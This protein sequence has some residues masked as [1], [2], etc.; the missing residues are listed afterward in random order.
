M[1]VTLFFFLYLVFIHPGV[2]LGEVPQLMADGASA[3]KAEVFDPKSVTEPWKSSPE[4]ISYGRSIYEA[5]CL[6]CHGDQG[7]GDGAAGAGLNPKPRNLVEGR[8]TQG[9]DSI[10]LLNSISKGIAG[11]SM[12]AFGHLSEVELWSLVHYIQS[13]TTNK[14]EDNPQSLDTYIK[15]RK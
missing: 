1:V 13:I 5:N 6:V 10:S 7:K 2:D 8:W 14:V 9:G 11:T 12:A 4:L 15:S 3:E